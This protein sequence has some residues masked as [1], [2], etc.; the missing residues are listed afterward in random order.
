MPALS[1][2]LAPERAV[3]EFARRPIE[4][5]LGILAN[6]ATAQRLDR[7]SAAGFPR[8][9]AG[10]RLQ[11][12]TKGAAMHEPLLQRIEQLERSMRRWRLVCFALG[13]IVVSLLA[14]GGT[15]GALLLPLLPVR[16]E[17][18]MLR[19]Q[20]VAERAQAEVARQRAED[21][22]RAERVARQKL[23]AQQNGP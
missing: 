17:M 22:L 23:Q 14:I 7:K 20:V 3:A 2:N 1:S 16:A 21:A 9:T 8:A 11:S 18:E 10:Y 4:S 13:I 6:S 15:F 12:A 19:A 5:T